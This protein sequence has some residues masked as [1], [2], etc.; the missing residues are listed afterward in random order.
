MKTTN[1]GHISPQEKWISRKVNIWFMETTKATWSTSPTSDIKWYQQVTCLWLII[2]YACFLLEVRLSLMIVIEF[3]WLYL[4][5]VFDNCFSLSALRRWAMDEGF[6]C[7]FLSAGL[8][9][10]FAMTHV[11]LG[12]TRV[13]GGG[14]WVGVSL[15]GGMSI[16]FFVLCSTWGFSS[17]TS[18]LSSSV[19]FS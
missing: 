14:C 17:S 3:V 10:T 7:C 18:T 5:I 11:A 9:E 8:L 12:A 2:F 15:D 4:M 19:A 13:G 1:K 16:L 6:C